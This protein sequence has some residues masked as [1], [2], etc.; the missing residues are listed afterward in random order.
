MYK[1]NIHLKNTKDNIIKYEL[2]KEYKISKTFIFLYK[3]LVNNK[4][5]K[6][7]KINS[8]VIH[9]NQIYYLLN[10]IIHIYIYRTA[11]INIYMK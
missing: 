4:K 10:K 1:K 8:E 11:N 9:I 7:F 5:Q 3:I 6:I 2:K